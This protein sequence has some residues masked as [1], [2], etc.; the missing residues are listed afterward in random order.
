MDD[1]SS[2]YVW[3]PR[4]KYR[5]F[6]I[7]G[8]DNVDSYDAY[9]KGIDIS[10][11]NLTSSSGLIYCDGVSCYK[12]SLK[13]IK[14]T[15][16]DNGKYYTHPAFSNTTK[17]LTGMWVSKY[18]LSE[19]GA[20][21][22]GNKALTNNNL[23][24]YFKQVKNMDSNNNYHVIKNTEWGAI[25]YLT[26]SKYGLCN[27]SKCNDIGINPTNISGSEPTDSTTGNIYGI[28]DMAGGVKEYTMGNISDNNSLNLANSHFNEV[29]L[30]T[31]DYDLYLPNTF[32]LGDATKELLHNDSKL[33]YSNNW[34]LRNGFTSYQSINDVG[35][36]TISTRIVTK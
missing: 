13:T 25:V 19:N 20:S 6:N 34:I 29:P 31:D 36:D 30:G 24:S 28:F 33:D 2:M 17:E 32:I 27:N 5:V 7:L 8:E 18:E 1:I 10:F 14:V 22:S 26:H 4:F 21:K 15:S 16:D 23:S 3:V 9:N 35:N 12:D 11:E